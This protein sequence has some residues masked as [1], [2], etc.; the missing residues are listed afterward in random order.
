MHRLGGAPGS[1]SGGTRTAGAC[2]RCGHGRVR[3]RSSLLLVL[4]GLAKVVGG[5]HCV[6]GG[7]F[8]EW[9]VEARERVAPRPVR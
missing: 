9:L 8:S 1:G 7:R 4:Q 2:W 6:A 3:S 5:V